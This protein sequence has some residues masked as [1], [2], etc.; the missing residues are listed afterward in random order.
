MNSMDEWLG[1]LGLSEYL[2]RFEE[3]A[4]DLSVV[5]DLTDGDLKD[6]GIPLGHRRKLLRAIAELGSRRDAQ[7][8]STSDTIRDAAERRHLTVLFCDMVGSTALSVQLDPEDLRTVISGY[9][10]AITD[11]I[12]AHQGVVARYMG[13]GL[14]AYFGYPEAHEDDAE[15]AARAGLKLVEAVANLQ[16]E[17]DAALQVRVGIATGTVVVGDLLI[18]GSNQE[19]GVVGETPNLAARL[20]TVA[21][22]GTVVICASTR[23]L[24][25]GQFEYR[26]LGPTAAKGWAQPVRAW[27]LVRAIEAESRFE[28]QHQATT[29]SPLIG[30]DEEI[31]LLLRRWRNSV[32]GEGRVFV[33]TGEPGIG[34]SRIAIA[35]Q[36]RLQAEPHFVLRHYCSAHHT[37]SVLFPFISQIERAAGFERSDSTSVK[38]EKLKSLVAPS[39]NNQEAAAILASLLSLPREVGYTLPELSPQK[40]KEKT[41]SALVGLFERQAAERPL[42]IVFEDVHW[43]DP[44]SL[45]LIT[46]L[47]DRIPQLRAML[48]I[49]SRPEFVPPWPSHAHVTTAPLTRLSKLGGT[50]LIQ[51]ITGGKALPEAVMDQ[52]LARTDGVPLFV[53]ELT[54]T[55]LESGLLREQNDRYE[56]D[57]PLPSLAIPTTLH[58]SLTAR[59][60][61]LAP[62]REVAQIGA[63]V[64]RQFSYELLMAV[65]G[66]PRDRL[67][68]ALAQLVS[69]ELVFCRGEVPQSV[70]TF[71]H[72]LVRDAAYGG[73]LKSRRVQLH[74]AIADAFERRF[75]EIVEAQPETLAHHLTEARLAE[76]AVKYWLIAGKKAAA[77]SANLEAIAHLERGLATLA[78]T[79]ANPMR[80]RQEVDLRLV[81]GPC[82]IATQGPA[83]T[84]AVE[85]FIRTRELCERLGDPPEY[86]QVM[87]WLTTASVM[88]GELP[89][90][91]E[92]ITA[93]L[94][95]ALAR[96]D[97]PALLNATRGQAMILLFMGQLKEANSV[98]EGALNAFNASSESDRLAARAAGQDAGVADMALMSWSLW[99]LGAVDDAAKRISAAVERAESI[100]HPHSVAYASY[101]ASVLHAL[102]GEMS[103][104]LAH[105]ERC[106]ALAEEHGFRQWHGLSRAMRGICMTNLDPDSTVLE[107]VEPTL[108]EYRT[109]GYQLGFTALCILLGDI[110]ISRQ[111]TESALEIIEKGLATAQVNAERIFESELYRLKALAL[112]RS[113]LPAAKADALSWLNRGLAIARDQQALS[114]ELR[115]VTDLADMKRELGDFEAARAILAPVYNRFTEGRDTND[116]KRAKAMLAGLGQAA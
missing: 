17:I 3:H 46:I 20:Q 1:S 43:I 97:Q 112:R 51:Q 69:S 62:V 113:G 109:A 37:N 72:V 108:E 50:A 6:I 75:P 26:E 39:G 55:V 44:T 64:G 99:L 52:I 32:E 10:S 54:K 19:Q 12:R 47:V 85:T 16:L 30:R 96:G 106:L 42:L 53:E 116:L 78:R 58:A 9:Q 66:L 28:A 102:R 110:Y 68:D 63:V 95:R 101:Y 90:A 67:D 38:F 105:A 71:K 29:L 49:T 114:L 22:P 70:Y 91:R 15:Q 76:R 92:T 59:L 31:E 27:Q 13:D 57:Q 65:A 21:A 84:T 73:L 61:R 89:L 115:L 40:H 23:R 36:D 5:G 104:A 45:E 82:L 111:Q 33:L 93:L 34:K 25:E 103:I 79:P 60:D 87:F 81:L 8:A 4:V 77:R 35:L 107:D 56:L 48:L 86:L 7:A 98:I 11:V 2:P 88:R 100:G 94:D 14:L 18:G 41:F 74:A 24:V 83:S 80:D